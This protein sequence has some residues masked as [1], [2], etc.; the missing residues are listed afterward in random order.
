[1]SR[2]RGLYASQV[3]R[4]S[5][6]GITVAGEPV[7][8]DWLLQ[9]FKDRVSRKRKVQL[10]DRLAEAFKRASIKVSKAEEKEEQVLI[11]ELPHAAEVDRKQALIAL[12]GYLLGD[13]PDFPT[14][15]E[16]AAS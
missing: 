15:D 6:Y 3:S 5:D 2:L 16:P 8:N 11:R 9:E 14:A 12:R 13:A 4:D 1:L 7:I 10:T